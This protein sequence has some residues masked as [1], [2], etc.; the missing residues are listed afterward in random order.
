FAARF[1]GFGFK[2]HSSTL[3]LARNMVN[4][5]Q[6]SELP[7]ERIWSE[8][9]KALLLPETAVFFRSLENL[10]ALAQLF[11]GLG[12][13]DIDRL[14]ELSDLHQATEERFALLISTLPP[15]AIEETCH[16]LKVP[17]QYR[18]LALMIADHQ[19]TWK[20]IC[21]LPAR[22][23]V[24][25][26]HILDAVRRPQRAQQFNWLCYSIMQ[27]TDADIAQKNSAT[28]VQALSIASSVG[29]DSLT[30]EKQLLQ[31][32]DL[33]EA[34]KEEQSHQLTEMKSRDEH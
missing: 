18:G 8:T 19:K 23:L 34:I 13:S 21:L 33:G 29:F 15:E 31:G 30:K 5:G 14:E 3:T 11:P 25:W 12:K 32:A 27:T 10:N 26:V 1:A 2:I 20:D 24:D 9:E 22:K 6:L 28:F 17:N 16:R 4:K 7:A